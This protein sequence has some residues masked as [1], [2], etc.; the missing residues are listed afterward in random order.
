VVQLTIQEAVENAKR[1]FL[2]LPGVT[3]V[4]HDGQSIIIY[5]ETAEIAQR[6]SASFMGYP[7]KAVVSGKFG[8]L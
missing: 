2:S 3:G 8:V 6:I 5:I 1:Q 4:S 7:V